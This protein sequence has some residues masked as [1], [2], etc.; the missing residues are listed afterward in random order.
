VSAEQHPITD[1]VRPLERDPDVRREIGG[2]GKD[3]AQLDKTCFRS[4]A[5]NPAGTAGRGQGTVLGLVAL[6]HRG[7]PA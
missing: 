1:D 5:E 7:R 6:T 4:H 2:L 3:Q